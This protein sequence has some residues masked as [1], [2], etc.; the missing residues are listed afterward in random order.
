MALHSPWSR[1]KLRLRRKRLL[2]RAFRSRRQLI[3]LKDRTAQ[4]ARDDILL[5]AT[6]RN[7]APRLPHFLEH[8]RGLGIGHFLIVDNG[9][10]DDTAAILQDQADVS[11]WHTQ[12]GYKAARFGMDWMT[13]LLRRYGHGHW[14][15]TVDAD[16][17]LIYP[18]WETRGLGQLTDGLAAEGHPSLGALMLDLFPKGSPDLQHYRPGTDPI[19]TA[20]WFDSHGYWC[21]RRGRHKAVSIV[22]GV[23]ARMFFPQAPDFA[24]VLSKVPL[25]RWKRSYVYLSSTHVALPPVLNAHHDGGGQE[26]LTGVLLHT[27][28]LPGTGARARIEKARGQQY[29]RGPAHEAYYDALAEAPDLWEPASVKFSGWQQLV[30]LGLMFRGHW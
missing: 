7:E 16:E 21:E 13:W 14:T 19:E 6:M 24:P 20:P 29:T 17:L 23:R 25:V 18:H 30:D 11:L 2:W 9:S 26:R 3:A 22:G 1:Y 28:F 5:F 4:I 10:E 8:Y 15:L 27:K 12:A